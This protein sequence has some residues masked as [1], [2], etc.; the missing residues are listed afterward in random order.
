MELVATLALPK[1]L[2]LLLLLLFIMSI[3]L[4]LRL[5]GLELLEQLELLDVLA[6]SES[7]SWMLKRE[8]VLAISL[9][10]VADRGKN[11]S[12]FSFFRWES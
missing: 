4:E 8:S 10:V 1:L 2:L 5:E 3:M 11:S 7:V 6:C 9:V 12:S